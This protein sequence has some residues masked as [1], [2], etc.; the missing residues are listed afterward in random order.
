MR[1]HIDSVHHGNRIPQCDY[2]MKKFSTLSYLRMH[3]STV[4]EGVR[5]YSCNI[6]QKSYTQKHSL[7]K[8]LRNSHSISS[9]QDILDDSGSTNGVPN[10]SSQS[11]CSNEMRTFKSRK[12]LLVDSPI[13]P[14]SCSPSPSRSN[15][16]SA[17]FSDMIQMH[18]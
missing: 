14:N 2:C 10:K 11:A 17:Y 18:H 9:S 15:E 13:I 16:V 6:C 12:R 4:H 5:A 7:K 8:H 1:V 3:I